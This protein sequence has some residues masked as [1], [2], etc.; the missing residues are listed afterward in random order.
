V[1]LIAAMMIVGYGGMPHAIAADP[2]ANKPATPSAVARAPGFSLKER[3]PA[4]ATIS[5][6]CEKVITLS[7][8]SGRGTCSINPADGS[9]RCDDGDGNAAAATCQSCRRTTGAGSCLIH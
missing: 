9:G 2:P 8:G 6:N 3:A 7:T 5:L 4:R 1:L